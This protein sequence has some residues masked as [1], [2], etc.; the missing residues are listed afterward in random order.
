[1]ADAK[2]FRV[3]GERIS[4][5]IFGKTLT[6][7]EIFSGRHFGLD[8]YQREYAWTEKQV[9]D[10]INDLTRQFSREWSPQHELKSVA[11][12]RPYFLGPVITSRVDGADYLIDG[13]QR[14]S[15]LMLLLIWLRRIQCGRDD[16]VDGIDPLVYS[17]HYG[18]KLFTVDDPERRPCLHALLN[19]TDFDIT[20]EPSASVRN[21][22]DR[23]GD[24]E[25]LFPEDLRD[26]ELP[27]F[28]YWLL[29]RV[30]LVEISTGDSGLALEIFETMNDRGLRLT[31]LD[32]LKS[33]V[34]TQLDTEDRRS[35][36]QVWRTRLTDL[37]DIDSNAH[38][39]FVKS[40]LRA[41]YSSGSDDDESIGSA[42]DK[43]VRKSAATLELDRPNGAR[44]F[45][46]RDMNYLAGRYRE[47]LL[48]TR[49]LTPNLEPV[50]YNAFNSVTLQ[51]PLILATLCTDDDD[52]TFKR[53][54][55]LVA[56]YLD[57]FVARSM[58]NAH[59]FR[60]A[61]VEH[62]LFALAREIR[63]MDADTLAKRLGDE[64]AAIPENFDAVSSF[65][66][67]PRNRMYVKYLLARIAAWLDAQC[68]TGLTFAHYTRSGKDQQP[69]E[70]EHIWA[71]KFAYQPNIPRRRFADLR[72]R[73]GALLLLPKDF[74]ASFGDMPYAK[75]LP[76]Y[77][78]QN[79]LARS[80]H[81]DCYQNNPT[82]LR[83][84]RDHKLPFQPFP[85][86][87]DPAAI[88]SRQELYRRLCE[89][90]WDPARYGLEMPTQPPR[91]TKARSR[92]RFDITLRQ[93]MD[94]GH[95]AAGDQLIG[96]YRGTDH[97]AH[98]TD[99][100]RIRIESGEEFEAASPAA[101]AVLETQSS[102]GWKFWQVVRPDGSLTRLDEVR[103]LA[104]QQ[105][106]PPEDDPDGLTDPK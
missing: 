56:G 20:R 40:W 7:R 19:G 48:A 54:A 6:V 81:P 97:K 22:W 83:M 94:Q 26:E 76:K 74:N 102:N 92:S 77:M 58:V 84:V 30:T 88:D 39:A 21:L 13:Q 86:A 49:T 38:S 67:R 37:T 66:L 1:L 96:S 47:L 57:I 31:S 89:I 11:K 2:E 63:G 4:D 73:L 24:I 36:N 52:S 3:A 5:Q 29:D 90:V 87:F 93:L 62:R 10:L 104:M 35:V 105:E 71:D 70:I 34:L 46:L 45:I 82:F 17:D 95:L 106:P 101:I 15:T 42:F 98:L 103:K 99:Q 9:E 28:I 27:F 51:L 79:L 75:K 64:V 50:Y 16:A 12:Y 14:L 53:K 43:W 33:F 59:D 68:L 72:N 85:E 41:K 61:T 69:Y 65:A 91:R 60:Y 100:A 25:R 80:L 78:G 32:L 55:A 44:E 8:S 18:Q 23:F